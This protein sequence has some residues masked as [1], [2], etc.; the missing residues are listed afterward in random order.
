MASA[1]DKFVKVGSDA[2]ITS[3]EAPGKSI[4]AGSINIGSGANWPTDTGVIFSIRKVKLEGGVSKLVD[5]TYTVW[6]GTISGNVVSSLTLVSGTDQAYSAGQDTQVYI[7]VSAEQHNSMV[8]GILVHADQDGTLKANAVDVAAVLAANVVETAKIKDAA[9]TTAKIAD[10]N[11]TPVKVTNPYKFRVYRNAALSIGATTTG[12]VTFDTENYDSNNNFDSTTNNRYVAPVAGFYSFKAAITATVDGGNL[13][14][15]ALYKNGT[16]ISLGDGTISAPGTTD[17]TWS[18]TDDL[19][20]AASDYI[21][22]FFRNG[23]SG[24]K[25][26]VTGTANTHFSGHLISQT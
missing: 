11:I 26:L 1:T 22:V 15:T 18:V 5:G 7:S 12:K 10:A 14:Y 9:V 25:S 6:R 2:T 24:T 21:E 19:Q 23:S 3:L 4:G 8:N 17:Q 13:F 16:L 20:L